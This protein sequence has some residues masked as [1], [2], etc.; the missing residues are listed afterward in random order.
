[1]SG[2]VPS[3]FGPVARELVAALRGVV[4][5]APVR[6]R[7]RAI[8][9][10]APLLEELLVKHKIG[11]ETPEDGLR[12]KWSKIVGPAIAHY[13]HAAQIDQRGRL[14]ILCSQPVAANELR[15]HQAAVLERVRAVPACGHVSGL[16]IRAG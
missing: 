11:R 1:M 3:A 13:T 9:S 6:Q 7:K 14:V 2:D 4:D 12:E 16:V 10:L 15:F 8:K 5:D